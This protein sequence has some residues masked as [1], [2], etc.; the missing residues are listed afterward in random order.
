MSL[1]VVTFDIVNT[2]PN[3]LNENKKQKWKINFRFPI[4][5]EN[6][7]RKWKSKFRF[8]TSQE[9]GK[10]KWRIKFRFPVSQENENRNF[11]DFTKS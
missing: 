2:S 1:S 5:Q 11:S 10:R 8:L 3:N 4:S 6:G 9:N 7:R